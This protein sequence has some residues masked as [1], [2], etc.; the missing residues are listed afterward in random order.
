[1]YKEHPFA[2]TPPA[3]PL[4]LVHFQFIFL[5][6][7][8]IG[9]VE[10]A[11]EVEELST[12]CELISAS[13]IVTDTLTN[14][15]FTVFAP[16]DQAWLNVDANVYDLISCTSALNSVFA[17]H[18]VYGSEIF[19]SDLQCGEKIAMDNGDDSRTV[20]KDDKIYQKGSLNSR[21]R[22]P[23]IVSVDIVACNGVVHVVDQ[24]M[25][26]KAKKIAICDEETPRPTD[27]T[28]DLPTN[29]I[30][31]EDLPADDN[32]TDDLIT[33]DLLTYDNSTDDLIMED[34]ATDDNSTEVDCLSVGKFT[35]SDVRRAPFIFL[36]FV[37]LIVIRL[38]AFVPN[39]I[40]ADIVCSDVELTDLCESLINFDI[41]LLL[42]GIYSPSNWTIF[43]PT[44]EAFLA[45]A[46]LE[47]ELSSEQLGDILLFHAIQ[48]QK[49]YFDD[50][51][52]TEKLPM[53]NKVMSRTKCDKD[54]DTGERFKIQ[55][56]SGQLDGKL[57]RI[58]ESD[59][60]ACNGIVHK[61]NNLMLPKL[62]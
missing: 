45:I 24:V 14:E 48:F 60:E 54:D 13:E 61:V 55:K 17:F 7:T 18:T 26:P 34:L 46:D 42:D 21:E 15:V 59:I 12:L 33:L 50:L 56:G 51:Q 2:S 39:F 32:S 31:M 36:L 6:I 47:S 3:H 41:L 22:M 11:C 16:T 27:P 8:T 62:N 30:I 23:E 19:S 35:N 57:P 10:I 20:C 43:A 58:I 29:D 53:A 1:M 40:L 4:V 9:S 44:D 5:P 52:C 38:L 28:E 49:L 25:L 37:F